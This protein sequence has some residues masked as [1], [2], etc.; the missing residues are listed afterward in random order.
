[1]NKNIRLYSNITGGFI[2]ILKKS[3]KGGDD[4]EGKGLE[5]AGKVKNL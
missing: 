2:R 1:M 3:Y 4:E 5:L